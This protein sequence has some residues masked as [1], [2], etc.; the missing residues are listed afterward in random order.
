M[1]NIVSSELILK[2]LKA[3]WNDRATVTQVIGTIAQIFVSVFLYIL[4]KKLDFKDKMQHKANIIKDVDFLLERISKGIS[5]KVEIVNVKKYEKYY[6]KNGYDRNGYTYL[7]SELKSYRYDGVE[8]WLDIVPV[9]RLPE[10][11]LTL[12]QGFDTKK[13]NYDVFIV[14][15]VP[16]EWIEYIDRYGDEWEGLPQFFA[17]FKG[18]GKY[19]Y[20]Y[21]KYYI[22]RNEYDTRFPDQQWQ[23]IYI[24]NE[25]SVDET[26]LFLAFPHEST[27]L[28]NRFIKKPFR[29]R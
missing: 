3:L 5:H 28:I 9:Y 25:K 29:R 27:I 6:P 21:Y 26:H 23:L 12:K 1:E 19:P 14:G 20:R 11:S 15:V 18:K 10:G 22:K 13:Q 8:F 4:S 16:Y 24:E 17:S 7:R 2:Y